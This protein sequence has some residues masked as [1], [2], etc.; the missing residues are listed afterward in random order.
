M[1]VQPWGL[2]PERRGCSFGPGFYLYRDLSAGV[3][4]DTRLKFEIHSNSLKKKQKKPHT[5]SSFSSPGK[6]KLELADLSE[7]VCSFWAGEG[8]DEELLRNTGLDFPQEQER[9][10]PFRRTP[11]PVPVHTPLQQGYQCNVNILI[12]KTV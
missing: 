8:L 1:P 3:F 6:I 5:A 12:Q 7:C 11:P 4:P 9:T 10:R 2:S